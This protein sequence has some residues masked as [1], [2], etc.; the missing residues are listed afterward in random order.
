MAPDGSDRARSESSASS[1]AAALATPA[2][3]HTEPSP[4]TV[5]ETQLP[6][7]DSPLPSIEQ[8]MGTMNLGVVGN[9]ASPAASRQERT[10][11]VIARFE[12]LD[13]AGRAPENTHG[14]ASLSP[15]PH[16]GRR[17]SSR[18]NRQSPSPAILP[19]HRVEDEKAPDSAF[20][21]ANFQAALSRSKEIANHLANTLSSSNLHADETSNIHSLYNQACEASRYS[22]PRSWRIGFVGD[23]GVGKFEQPDVR[24][25]ASA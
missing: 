5:A 10:P 2:S 20:Y 24:I 3:S 16:S 19:S 4:D 11:S 23:I 14:G 8:A 17:R 25:D 9:A 7:P 18:A 22:G 21:S 6:D 12:A 15:E 1:S 13:V